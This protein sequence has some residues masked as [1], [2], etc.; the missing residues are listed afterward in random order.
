MTSRQEH[1]EWCKARAL[2][3]LDSGDHV[4]AVNSMISDLG[5]HEE[6]RTSAVTGAMLLHEI[7]MPDKDSVRRFIEGFK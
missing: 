7:S 4:N 2:Q 3:Y 5:K 1:L 6:T